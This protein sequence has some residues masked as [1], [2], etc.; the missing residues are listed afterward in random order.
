MGRIGDETALLIPGFVDGFCDPARQQEADTEKYQKADAAD[1]DTAAQQIVQGRLF[2]RDIGVDEDLADGG[3]GAVKAEMIFFYDPDAAGG[4][5]GG[6][7]QVFEK[8]FVGQVIISSAEG[9]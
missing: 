4:R 1:E 5:K 7:D 6:A 9:G 8:R 2:I 3:I